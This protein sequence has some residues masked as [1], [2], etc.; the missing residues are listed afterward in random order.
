[1]LVANHFE[2]RYIT[3]YNGK[4]N[5][6]NHMDIYAELGNL[7]NEANDDKTCLDEIIAELEGQTPTSVDEATTPK[8]TFDA[9]SKLWTLTQNTTN[10]EGIYEGEY[11]L[12]SASACSVIKEIVVVAH[13]SPASGSPAKLRP[14][15]QT[16]DPEPDYVDQ[17]SLVALKHQR[18]KNFIVRS[19]VPFEVKLRTA[20]C[21][22]EWCCFFDF[23]QAD[24]GWM[25]QPQ[26]VPWARAVG[27]WVAG[28]GWTATHN[29]SN[30]YY[31]VAVRIHKTFSPTFVTEATMIF[32]DLPGSGTL[33]KNGMDET[34]AGIFLQ[35]TGETGTN[36]AYTVAFNRV[37]SSL[38][39]WV[40]VTGG[41]GTITGSGRLISI[42]LH[43]TGLN[44]F[45]ASSC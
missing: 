43:G 1:M 31:D 42:T 34:G 9:A 20:V 23:T 17:P 8:P 16:P 6:V 4:F 25:S 10:G 30:G 29:G 32:D 13:Q 19:A 2:F 41:V 18:Y 44:P 7:L 39:A 11:G 36:V 40:T 38:S 22:G 27:S 12:P 35:G 21:T 14:F 24:G 45:G 28:Q 15:Y 37:V 33:Y 5:G 3:D 26:Y